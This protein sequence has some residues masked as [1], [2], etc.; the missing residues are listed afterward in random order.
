MQFKAFDYQICDDWKN[1]NPWMKM[2]QFVFNCGWVRG[3]F[4]INMGWQVSIDVRKYNNCLGLHEVIY[5]S[6]C[7][8]NWKK[9][10]TYLFVAYNHDI[11]CAIIQQSKFM[12]FTEGEHYWMGPNEVELYFCVAHWPIN[13]K[14]CHLQYDMCYKYTLT[15]KINW[16]WWR[17]T[18][19]FHQKESRWNFLEA[20]Q[21]C[22]DYHSS[23]TM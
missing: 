23:Y 3:N 21:G 2:R 11:A 6:W 7:T 17:C 19:Q 16:A 1:T 20:Q 12:Y 8:C 4:A 13:P 22:C 5:S 15:W 9:Q 18:F 14:K 10:T